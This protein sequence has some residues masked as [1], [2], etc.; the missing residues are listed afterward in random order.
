MTDFYVYKKIKFINTIIF[1]I[2]IKEE[3]FMSTKERI[4]ALLKEIKPTADLD[5]VND[6]ID[7]GYLDSMELMGLI[8]GLMEAFG[9]E[10]DLDS[11][12]PDNFNSVEAMVGMVEKLQ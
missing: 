4:F 2:I 6:I 7:G 5:G 1:L 8:S 9:I 12:T 10:I 11:I 3:A